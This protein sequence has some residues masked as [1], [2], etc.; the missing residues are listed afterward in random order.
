MFAGKCLE[1]TNLQDSDVIAIG[2]VAT[3]ASATRLSTPGS[4]VG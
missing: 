1:C 3:T 4:E 2:R